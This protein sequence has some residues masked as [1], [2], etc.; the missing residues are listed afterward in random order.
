VPTIYTTAAEAETPDVWPPRP[1][2]AWTS[3]GAQRSRDM[4][5]AAS[6]APAR[7][8]DADRSCSGAG[9]CFVP[10]VATVHPRTEKCNTAI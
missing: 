2:G 7:R 10:H 1:P 5:A 3:A 4:G 6:Q 9:T 8:A